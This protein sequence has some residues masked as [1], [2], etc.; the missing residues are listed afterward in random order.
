MAL[1]VSC[2]DRHHDS[3]A[4]QP[5][6]ADGEHTAACVQ[7]CHGVPAVQTVPSHCPRSS[8]KFVSDVPHTNTK[9]PRADLKISVDSDAGVFSDCATTDYCADIDS[10]AF[11]EPSTPHMAGYSSLNPTL[12]RL[13]S[14]DL[15]AI[16]PSHTHSA[17]SS[18]SRTPSPPTSHSSRP[19]FWSRGWDPTP[20]DDDT[21]A[22]LPR[23]VASDGADGIREFRL[24]SVEESPLWQRRK[25]Q[26]LLRRSITQ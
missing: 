14:T 18:G 11:D 24:G 8:V 3:C 4:A 16:V 25:E 10:P 1:E 9:M 19:P 13:H 12:F 26:R 21:P 15:E 2:G 22:F 7:S 23:L 20:S 5:E 6:T 17:D